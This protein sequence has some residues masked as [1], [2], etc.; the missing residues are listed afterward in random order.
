MSKIATGNYDAV[1]IGHTQL[2][3]LPLSPERQEKIYKEQIENIVAGIAELKHNE[4]N[5]FKVKD[6]ERT[7]R[8]LENQLEKLQSSKKDNTVYFEELGID[9]LFIDEAHEFKNLFCTTKLQNVSGISSRAS[10]RATELFAK[11]RYLDEKTGGKGVVFATGTPLSNSVT[12]LHT[13]MRYL[14]YDF[15]VNHNNM[16]NFD[17]WVST[18]GTQKRNMNLLLQVTNLKKEPVSPNTQIC[19]NLCQCSK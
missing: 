15:L 10:Q 8:N 1:I 12:E 6:M 2:K 14:N 7:K 9:K 18:F 11:C 17:N 19:R 13:M 16:Q 5:G 3:M 4:G